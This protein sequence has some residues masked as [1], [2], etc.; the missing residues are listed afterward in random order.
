M[1][2]NAPVV[3]TQAASSDCLDIS[4]AGIHP[5]DDHHAGDI[6]SNRGQVICAL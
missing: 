2:N 4:I 5:A 1:K 6:P 3:T